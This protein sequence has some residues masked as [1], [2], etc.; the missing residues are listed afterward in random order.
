MAKG[1]LV[2]FLLKFFAGQV[3]LDQLLR[4]QQ[5]YVLLTHTGDSKKGEVKPK[6][7]F[8]TIQL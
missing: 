5:N 2:I 7:G 1:D 3:A 6:F 4:L 8:F